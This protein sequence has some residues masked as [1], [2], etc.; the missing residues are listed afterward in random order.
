MLKTRTMNERD[1]LIKHNI[2]GRTVNYFLTSE[3]DLNEIK[4]KSILG[5]ISV[6]ICSVFIGGIVSIVVTK[7]STTL[8][9]NSLALVNLI[10]YFFIGISLVTGLLAAYFYKSSF[11]LI[12][13]IKES[14]E[15]KSLNSEQTPATGL[16]I[17]S[18]LY[19]TARNSRNVTD[20]LQKKIKN[21]RLVSIANNSLDADPNFDPE[22]GALKKLTVT[23]KYSGTIFQREY[24]EHA[25]LELP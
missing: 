6:V 8:A 3:T 7:I 10:F 15:I 18:A 17:I 12:K 24:N 4:S 5:D 20:I 9:N 16:E 25:P 22:P 21:N 11:D 1:E 13:T 19:W 14:G 2:R 23:Y